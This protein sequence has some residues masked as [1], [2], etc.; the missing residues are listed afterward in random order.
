[1]KLQRYGTN[2]ILQ[3]RKNKWES[4]A[5]FNPATFLE[6]GEIHVLYRAVGD[7]E[8]YVSK[9]GHAV[10]DT[11]LK[12]LKRDKKPCFEPCEELWEFSI[13]DPRVVKLE[14]TFFITYVITP[15]PCAPRTIRER[16]GIPE[17]FPRLFPRTAL[18]TTKDFNK[19]ERLGFITPYRAH[20]RDVVLFP[21]KIDGKYG[22]LHRP[23]NWIGR[24]FPVDRPSIWFAFADEL[25]GRLHSHQV[26]LEPRQSWERK[27]IG[28]GAPPILTDRGWLLI[29]H[30]VDENNVYRA[31]A[32]LLDEK[33]PWKVIARS[34][35][36]ILEPEEEYERIGDVPNVVFPE[37]CVVVE[38]ELI[39]VYGAADKYCCAAH[40][41]LKKLLDYLWSSK[42]KN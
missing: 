4:V 22:I 37:G 16:L 1:M 15:S 21:Q 32:A 11:N 2:P 18:A 34:S 36:P 10:F 40:V 39:V 6:N 8:R 3:P 30:G 35:L 14:S 28:A 42:K 19:F 20:E 38:N 12:L 31:G 5:V 26:V 13:E 25:P 27:K 24:E 41:S 33:K 7:Y 17:P 9:I 29:Y 23:S